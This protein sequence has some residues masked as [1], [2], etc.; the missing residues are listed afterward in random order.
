MDSG[1]RFEAK[2]HSPVMRRS[3]TRR[4]GAGEELLSQVDESAHEIGSIR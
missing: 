2:V 1:R 4:R 3:G